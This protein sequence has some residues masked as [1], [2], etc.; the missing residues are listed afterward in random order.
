M[1]QIIQLCIFSIPVRADAGLSAGEGA[2]TVREQLGKLRCWSTAFPAM[3][4]NSS[5]QS[6]TIDSPPTR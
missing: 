6:L 2:L 5:R 1:K 3:A 4:M